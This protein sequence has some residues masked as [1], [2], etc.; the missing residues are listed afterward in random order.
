MPATLPPLNALKAFESAARTGSYVA[1]AEELAVSPA[2]VSQQVR[3]LEEFLGRKLFTRLNNRILLTEAGSAIAAGSTEALQQIA[4]LTQQVK[5]GAARSRLVV[6]VLPSVAHRW[7]EKRIADFLV[8]Q[9]T[10]PLDLRIE[11]DPVD[12][13][14]GAIDLRLCYGTN[15][16]PDHVTLKLLDDEVLPFCGPAYLAR[17]PRA[18]NGMDAVPEDDLIHTDWGPSFVSQPAWSAW[19]AAQGISRRPEGR[20]HRVGMSGLALDFARDGVGV[21]LGP[22]LMAEDDLREGRLV[23]LSRFSIPL[24]HPYCLVH[25]RGREKR[26]DLKNLI[27]WLCEEGAKIGSAA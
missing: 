1:A 10:A 5:R 9:G 27:G 20:G 25:P 13:A 26:S 17:N 7:F 4:Q 15:L 2:A 16:Y 23:A 12:F 6:S 3:L 21:A 11:D 8:R 14:R 18:A 24:A 19:F 22:R